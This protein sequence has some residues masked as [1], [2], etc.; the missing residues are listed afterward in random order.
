MNRQELS[1]YILN[2]LEEIRSLKESDFELVADITSKSLNA[3]LNLDESDFKD[4]HLRLSFIKTKD[5]VRKTITSEISSLRE[6]SCSYTNDNFFQMKAS[7]TW[8][9]I[10]IRSSE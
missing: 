4:D 6:N 1:N 9:F 3:Y 8:L 7:L 10:N 5:I 2:S